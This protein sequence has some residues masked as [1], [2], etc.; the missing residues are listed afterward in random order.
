[1]ARYKTHTIM[2]GETIQGIAQ[3]E[4]GDVSNWVS[5]VQHNNLV[6]PY[7]VSTIAEKKKN[8]E[9]LVVVGDKLI[10]PIQRDLL[11][12]INPNTLS[13]RDQEF[14]LSIALGRDLDMTT[15]S[16]DINKYGTS[17]EILELRGNGNGDIA[18]V[19][20]VENVKQATITRLCTPKGSLI[21]HPEYGSELYNLFGKATIEQM[22]LI[23]VEIIRTVLMDTRITSCTLRTHSITGDVYTGTYKATI[24]DLDKSF[25][26]LVEGDKNG[27]I[28]LL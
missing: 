15:E 5:I 9:H 12:D 1:M 20:G 10:I 25:Q 23:A 7:I 21:L 4:T 16:K 8:M 11:E 14:I 26:I 22:Q 18:T 24:Q 28:I 17:N 3:K 13:K 6:Y 27:N 19:W 2:Q